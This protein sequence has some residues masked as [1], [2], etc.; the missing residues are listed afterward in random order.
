VGNNYLYDYCVIR[1]VPKVDREE[2]INA[3]V[4][5]SCE[6]KEFLKARVE[7]DEQRLGAFYPEF[8]IETAKTHLSAIPVICAGTAEAG[9][10]GQLSKRKR[11]YWLTS[12]KS[13]I[14]Q[15]SPVH[16]G[17]CKDPDKELKHLFEVLVKKPATIKK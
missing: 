12:P 6:E 5:L 10:I 14:V 13:T 3:G 11:F 9:P 1:I 8:D 4:I 17:Y 15:I 16:S 2:F 7:L